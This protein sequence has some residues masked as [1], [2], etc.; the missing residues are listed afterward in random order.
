MSFLTGCCLIAHSCLPVWSVATHR[1]LLCNLGMGHIE[2]TASSGS[3]VACISIAADTSLVCHCLTVAIS[4]GSTIPAFSCHFTIGHDRFRCHISHASILYVL[5]PVIYLML[6]NWNLNKLGSSSNV[7][8]FYSG[9]T[10]CEPCLWYWLSWRRCF[11]I[12]FSPSRIVP[13]IKP[14]SHP[15]T[16]FQIHYSLIILSLDAVSCDLQTR[17][18]K[19]Q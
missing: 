12:F 15:F 19:K 10:W 4:S 5:L 13:Q 1:F 16:F 14:F 2:N 18:I 3:V 11:M 17:S 7:S 8:G 6:C 9:D